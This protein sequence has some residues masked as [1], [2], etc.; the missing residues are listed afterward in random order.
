MARKR[1]ATLTEAELRLMEILWEKGEASVGEIV[2]ALPKKLPLAYSTVLTTMRILE[3]KGYVRHTEAGRAYV[4]RALVDRDEARQTA[5]RYIVSRF[6]RDSPGQL[7]LNVL[8]NEK[9][10]E[11]ELARLKQLIEQ[12]EERLP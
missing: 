1:S 10:S 5:V 7:A 12:S 3:Q 11:Q 9:I 4:Y 6:F 8:Q 2:A